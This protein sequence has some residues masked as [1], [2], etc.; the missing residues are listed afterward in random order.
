MTPLGAYAFDH[1][2]LEPTK[3]WLSRFVTIARPL[4]RGVKL[5]DACKPRFNCHG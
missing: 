2:S 3:H 5:Y 4:M 1:G